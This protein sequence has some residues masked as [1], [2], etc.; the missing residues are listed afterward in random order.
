MLH[1]SEHWREVKVISSF[2]AFFVKRH[3]FAKAQCCALF[4]TRAVLLNYHTYMQ[5]ILKPRNIGEAWGGGGTLFFLKKP[6]L[7]MWQ[8]KK[9]KR[10]K[11]T[12]YIRTRCRK[13]EKIR[14]VPTSIER[15]ILCF[16]FGVE[17]AARHATCWYPSV[18][19]LR[20]ISSI[21]LLPAK[22][23]ELVN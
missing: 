6:F 2:S 21:T 22:R 10:Q 15:N 5:L 7:K 4:S 18:W 8:G 13:G 14:F 12:F 11:D 17:S 20:R 9:K 16:S 19:W 3:P 23:R 1:S